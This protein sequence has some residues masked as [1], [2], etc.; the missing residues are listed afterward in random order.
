MAYG[1]EANRQTEPPYAIC[2]C[3]PYAA[4]SHELLFRMIPNLAAVL[5]LMLVTD[6]RLLGERD[7]VS[8]CQAAERGGVTC[9]QLR[10]KEAS[11]RDLL[12]ILRRLVAAV[13]V[14][15]IVNDRLDVGLAGD[16]HGV[17]LGP[18]DIPL[19]LARRAAPPGFLLGGSVGAPEEVSASEPADYWGVGPFR[20][21]STK[22]DAG[23]ALGPEGLAAIIKLASPGKVCVAIGGIRPTDI[24]AVF[25]AGAQGVA[26]VSGILTAEDVEAGARSYA[27]ALEGQLRSG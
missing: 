20:A 19:R 14:P 8:V 9:I 26:V 12:G 13:R 24:P 25:A 23:A 17:H 21:T 11:P 15:V 27:V 22:G 10:L 1:V 7:P 6:D 2:C 4:V 18:D 16:A 5:R 3:M